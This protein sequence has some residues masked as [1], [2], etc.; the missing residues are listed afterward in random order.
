M[1]AKDRGCS[2]VTHNHPPSS[3]HDRSFP[4]VFIVSLARCRRERGEGLWEWREE[5]RASVPSAGRHL[6][7]SIAGLGIMGER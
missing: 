7:V 4:L 5:A 6:I 1:T 3:L 2:I